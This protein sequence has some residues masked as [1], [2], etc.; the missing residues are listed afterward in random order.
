M[1]RVEGPVIV[2]NTHDIPLAWPDLTTSVGHTLALEPG[3]E[4]MLLS[5]PGQ[6]AHLLVRPVSTKTSG[7]D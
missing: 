5:D 3:E 2:R 1:G 6:V 4:A 7:G